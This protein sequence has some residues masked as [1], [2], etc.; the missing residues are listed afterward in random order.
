MVTAG[1]DCVHQASVEQVAEATLRVLSR[2]LPPAVP[3]VVFLSGG[4]TPTLATEHLNAL[5]QQK[6]LPWQLSFS[7]G[8]ALQEP[9]LKSWDGL[10][11]NQAAAQNALYNR[12][13]LNGAARY[14]RILG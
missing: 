3:G 13:K 14:G 5:N 8:R 6:Y 4:Q 1:K 10:D 11:K 2:C 12:A 9:V 7:F